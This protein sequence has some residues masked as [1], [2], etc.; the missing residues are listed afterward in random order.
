MNE[1]QLQI[2]QKETP[3]KRAKRVLVVDTFRLS[4]LAVAKLLKDSDDL[5]Y[6]GE[7]DSFSRALKAVARLKPDVVVTEILLH[8]DFDLIHEL[9]RR[10]P[11]LPILVFSYRDEDWYAPRSL[12]AGADGFLSK[13]VTAQELMDSIRAVAGGRLVL[14]ARI[15]EQLLAKCMRRGCP[16]ARQKRRSVAFRTG[17][18]PGTGARLPR[19]VSGL[20]R[21]EPAG[22]QHKLAC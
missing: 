15:R 6:C 10:H 9:R 1:W 17:R 18:M 19:R 20:E 7:A 4:R 22:E 8:Q 12:E 13:A 2:P 11:R 3:R 16:F 21:L 5:A 14:S